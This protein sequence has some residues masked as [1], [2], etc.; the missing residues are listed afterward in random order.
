M[1]ELGARARTDAGESIRP[2]LEHRDRMSRCGRRFPVSAIK[3]RSPWGRAFIFPETGNRRESAPPIS[4]FDE[5]DRWPRRHGNARSFERVMA[6][7]ALSPARKPRTGSPRLEGGR[8]ESLPS[9]SRGGGERRDF[10]PLGAN[11]PRAELSP[12]PPTIFLPYSPAL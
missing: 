8:T 11:R 10:G 9:D 5:R 3:A 12:V 1:S 4:R 7:R 2:G 6:P